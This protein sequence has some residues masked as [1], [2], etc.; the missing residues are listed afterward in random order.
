ML[1]ALNLSTLADR[2]N[3]T[4][5]GLTGRSR[6][7]PKRSLAR[8]IEDLETRALLTTYVVNTNLDEVVN[9]SNT[10]LREAVELAN[11]NPGEDS[12]TFD[13]LA[14]GSIDLVSGQ[15]DITDALTI[16][17]NGATHTIINA[18]HASRV[19]DVAPSAGNVTFD[20]LAITN[21]ETDAASEGGAGIRFLSTGTLTVTNSLVSGNETTDVS[22]SGAGIYAFNATV[23]ISASTISNNST[24]GADSTGGGVRVDAGSL[25]FVNSTISGNSTASSSVAG[26][27]ISVGSATLNVN[28][29]TVAYNSAAGT[30]LFGGGVFAETGAATITNSIVALNINAGAPDLSFGSGFVT[31]SNSLVGDSTGTTLV[32]SDGV[33]DG[34]GN[35]IGS[36]V[37]PVDPV[38]GPLDLNG[39]ETPTHALMPNSPAIDAGNETW[40]TTDADQRGLPFVRLAGVNVDMGAFEAQ[41]LTLQ[42]T[43]ADDENDATL[44]LSDLSLREAL[45]YANAFPGQDV[46]S[47]SPNLNGV[48]LLL[49]LGQLTISDAVRII[50]SGTDFTV[51]NAQGAS[52]VFDVTSS[53]GDVTF[54]DLSIINGHTTDDG[55]GGAGIRFSSNGVLTLSNAMVSGNVTEGDDAAGGG[56]LM[57]GTASLVVND[58]TISGNSTLGFNAPGGGVAVPLGGMVTLTDSRVASNTTTGDDSQ[59]GGIYLSTGIL[60]LNTSTVA[61]N[62]TSG[63]ESSG[64]GIHSTLGTVTSVDSTIA[65]NSTTGD[66]APGGGLFVAD[67]SVSLTS[68]TVSGNQTQGDNGFGG[69]IRIVAGTA[70]LV[71]ST[72]STNSTTGTVSAGG[73]LSS[74]TANLTLTNC[75]VAFNSSGDTTSGGGGVYVSSAN[76]SVLNSIIA[77]NSG[78]LAPDLSPG[79]GGLTVQYSLIGINVGTQLNST[80][81][82]SPDDDGNLIGSAA[83]PIEPQL[84]VLAAYSGP[85]KTH[86]LQGIS[87]AINAG[88]NDLANGLNTDQRGLPRNFN[89]T[90]DMGAFEQQSAPAQPTVSFSVAAQTVSEGVG[91]VTLTVNLSFASPRH[92]TVPF[93]AEGTAT[94]QDDFSFSQVS[95]FIP[96]GSLSATFTMTIVDD[97]LYETNETAVVTFGVPINAIV[98]STPDQTITI[99]NND[100]PPVVSLSAAAGT[101]HESSGS[102]Q[103]TVNLSAAAGVDI[104]VPFTMGGTATSPG[105]YSIAASP[106][107]IPAGATSGTVTATVVDDNIYEDNKT[108]RLSLGTPVNATLGTVTNETFTLIDD[109]NVAPVLGDP[110]VPEAYRYNPRSTRHPVQPFASITVEDGNGPTELTRVVFSVSLPGG[111]KNYDNLIFNGASTIASVN[112]TTASGRRTITLTLKSG[113]TSA[114]VQSFLRNISFETKRTS[115]DVPTRE[116]RVQVTDRGG[117]T[118]NLV[119]QVVGVSKN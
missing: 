78:L 71:N 111:R 74:D 49:T 53:A 14:D 15:L 16:T 86:S 92:V 46:I 47:F 36:D 99:T 61:S 33:L 117:L 56:I 62:T 101:T 116:F 89:G 44:D 9:D 10:S 76:L 48:P 32:P 21:G 27:G 81:L 112:D 69:G 77:D 90:V 110:G 2:L 20:R 95:V 79:S 68:S 45:A 85:T 8:R 4:W 64:G 38:L 13:S 29:S 41:P 73:G 80:P 25:G 6:R 98:G 93:S 119:T 102:F 39:G 5:R 37:S 40:I 42:V 94:E 83:A 114:Q 22:S 107:V 59:G 34:D 115:L 52:R 108:I 30:T 72:I 26:G 70:T 88:S 51:I 58:S 50:G 19:F 104:T 31:V 12:I 82:G 109:D 97:N 1:L 65:D 118:S 24:I 54:S 17:G 18:Q 96:A 75:T 67:A 28:G 11:A 55:E 7:L 3:E 57:A 105:D 103:Y 84:G 60:V 23:A 113:V 91:T 43:T 100:Q 35:L 106:L 66:D 63:F 87:P